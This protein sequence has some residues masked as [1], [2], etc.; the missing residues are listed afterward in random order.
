MPWAGGAHL[1]KHAQKDNIMHGI[2]FGG[3]TRWKRPPTS[4]LPI[5]FLV[6][7]VAWGIYKNTTYDYNL[8]AILQEPRLMTYGFYNGKHPWK[9]QAEL[10]IGLSADAGSKFI[11][12][13]WERSASSILQDDPPRHAGR[14][15]NIYSFIQD[16]FDGNV[17]IYSNFND[18]VVYLQP[19]V[20]ARDWPWWVAWPDESYDTLPGNSTWWNRIHR[21]KGDYIIDQYSWKGYAPDYGEQENKKSMDLNVINPNINLDAFL[22][23]TPTEPPPEP[24]GCSKAY[25]QAINLAVGKLET[26]KQELLNTLQEEK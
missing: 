16:N 5:D 23:I 17:G 8:P 25:N 12:I 20:N 13:D 3:Y 15:A 19:Y 22:G 10:W 2:D 6:V 24:G 18:Y 4:P 7:G 14:C 1:H 21:E 26:L 11:W 9:E